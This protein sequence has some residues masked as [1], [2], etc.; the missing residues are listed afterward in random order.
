MAL[1]ICW[2]IVDTNAMKMCHVETFIIKDYTC[3]HTRPYTVFRKMKTRKCGCISQAYNGCMNTSHMVGH[4]SAQLYVQPSHCM[5]LSL[6]RHPAKACKSSKT[7]LDNQSEQLLQKSHPMYP[8]VSTFIQN[9]RE[10]GFGS[11]CRLVPICPWRWDTLLPK[12]R[13]WMNW[14]AN[15]SLVE[16]WLTTSWGNTCQKMLLGK[17]T[18]NELPKASKSASKVS[19]LL[20]L[21]AIHHH[22]DMQNNPGN[23]PK[24]THQAVMAQPLTQALQP[25]KHPS[26]KK[27]ATLRAW[28]IGRSIQQPWK[29]Q[30]KG[31][32]KYRDHGMEIVHVVVPS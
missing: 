1:L 18:S 25:Q 3:I 5:F 8:Y 2:F 31:L 27:G 11:Y 13:G 10:T 6:G 7:Q 21:S 29:V 9:Y 15:L 20:I 30:I 19:V 28:E 32:V 12:N 22:E 17:M 26:L 24:P 14:R 16:H 23:K 4:G